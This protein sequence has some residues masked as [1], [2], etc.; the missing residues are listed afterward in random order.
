[1]WRGP[2]WSGAC[3]KS[4]VAQHPGQPREPTGG[5]VP[6]GA[7]DASG[8]AVSGPRRW[9]RRSWA[10]KRSQSPSRAAA[11]AMEA[12]RGDARG[13]SSGPSGDGPTLP[14][15]RPACRLAVWNGCWRWR[16]PTASCSARRFAPWGPCWPSSCS[17][18]STPR[19]A[20]WCRGFGCAGRSVVWGCPRGAACPRP[21]PSRSMMMDA[22][23]RSSAA[24][25]P[26]GQPSASRRS[27]SRC[28]TSPPPTRGPA[29]ATAPLRTASCIANPTRRARS[30]ATRRVCSGR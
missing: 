3:V 4:T 23:S 27:A 15:P 10:G 29:R 20:S 9:L 21:L 26:T 25:S 18:P 1:V 8:T 13:S 7:T 30:S 12:R 11:W 17:R 6:R 22:P 5:P 16:R 28:E 14:P 2:W 24:T 19:F